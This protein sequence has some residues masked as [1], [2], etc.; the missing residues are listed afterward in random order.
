MDQFR[1]NFYKK[2]IKINRNKNTYFFNKKLIKAKRI[3]FNKVNKN[4]KDYSYINFIKNPTMITNVK[5]F[6]IIKIYKSFNIKNIFFN[7]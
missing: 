3:N 2:F 4:Y 5:T 7:F 6:N 1:L